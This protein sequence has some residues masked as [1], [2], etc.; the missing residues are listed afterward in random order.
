MKFRYSQV[1]YY[2]KT[3]VFIQR[4]AKLDLVA[5]CSKYG[6]RLPMNETNNI[7]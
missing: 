4:Q 7:K 6:Y 5:N 2:F 1:D 3:I